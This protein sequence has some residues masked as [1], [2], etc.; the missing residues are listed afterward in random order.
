M[1][2]GVSL[3][4][5][6]L[7]FAITERAQRFRY[8][9]VDDLEVAA[10]GELLE[11][12]QR[13]VGLDAG[14]I[15]VHDEADRA[16]R[17]DDGCLG[18]AVAVL[19]AEFQRLVPGAHGVDDEVL[20]RI[21]AM[22]EGDRVDRERLVAGRL[23][24]G[25]A[26]MVA[27]D[28]QHV[29][30]VRGKARERTQLLGHFG[31]GGV[32][33][34]SHDRR[35]RAGDGAAFGAVIGN[36]RGHQQAADV[37]ITEAE[38]AVFVGEFGNLAGREL[39]HHDRD[40]KDDGPQ[41][42]GVL[43]VGDVDALGRR[44]L[45]HHQ[46]QRG[47]VAGGVVEEHV[48]RA[49][50][51]RADRAG[52]RARVP[53]V[54]R[55]VEVQ[56]R[57]GGR[58][59]GVGDR[60][61]EVTGL[62]RLH[63]AAVLAGG[64]LPVAIGFDGAQEVVL[65]RDRVVGVLARNREIGFRIPVGVVGLELEVLVA[66]LGK[67]DDALDVVFR[68]Q[69]LLGSADLALQRRVLLRVVAGV[70]GAV[71]VDAGLHDRLQ[72]FGDDLG[73]GDKRSDLLLFLDLP[74]DVF[75]DIRMVDID[76]DHLGGAAGGATRLDGAGGAV[77]DLQE[78]H[79]A[80]G[81]AAA[82]E[83]FAFAAQMREVG[84][85]ARAILEQARF[86][87]PE[88]HDAAFVDEIVSDRLDKAGMRLRMLVGRLRLGQLAGEGIDIEVAL[89]G[90]IDAIG[91]VQAGVEP[92]RRVRRDALGGEHV[93]EFVLEGGGVF[94]RVEVA[95]LPAPIGPGAGQA[96]ENLAGIGLGTVV[97]F[98]GQSLQ[99]IRVRDRPPEEGGDVV[100]LDA[101]HLGRNAGLAE[102]LL[103]ENVGRDLAELSRNVD[104]G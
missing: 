20:V 54:H 95:A 101:L 36:A 52:G 89:A 38:R 9:T 93:G 58:P 64:Q 12:H 60:L 92:L 83:L 74:V 87:H 77:A 1:A 4:L 32:G 72:V 59:G 11:F 104:I 63:H 94:F 2:D 42:D 3:D 18:V 81:L 67:L 14:R 48:L 6:D 70:V 62:Q 28:A 16:G 22:D 78:R 99:R 41:A 7:A 43:V 56:A 69:R 29:V 33:N 91:P 8:G 100:L 15:A 10:A 73:T 90:A 66:L 47:E 88:V 76:N 97:F 49:R 17:R 86:T 40:F 27:D 45:E 44:I 25:G 57:I 31:R 84:A 53:V 71:A 5:G 37:G 98:L 30:A 13:E 55:R 103:G 51:R 75:L 34:T 26:A 50:V 21:V 80:G 24:I 39:R 61:P 85:G 46:V 79:Q 82:R 68:N 65:D 102:I 96:I 35:Q 23:A 19:F